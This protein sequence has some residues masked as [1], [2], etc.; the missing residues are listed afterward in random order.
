[1]E[2]KEQG[3]SLLK[4]SSDYSCEMLQYK[5]TY[6]LSGKVVN[7]E[8]I[9]K[10]LGW[11]TANLD[12]SPST[13]HLKEGVY[14]AKA[15]FRSVEYAAALVISIKEKKTKIEVYLIDYVGDDFY[16][17]TL[18]VEPIQQVSQLELKDSEEEL[19]E[20]IGA[21]MELIRDVLYDR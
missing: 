21:D 10:H 6:M 4:S 11:P 1:M 5:Y 15:Y 3:K 9:G 2:L 14:A 20:K 17:E 7:G 12:I 8:G 16:G 13:T 18:A 19:K